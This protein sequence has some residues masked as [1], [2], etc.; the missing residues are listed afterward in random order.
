MQASASAACL[1][2]DVL[3]G[4]LSVVGPLRFN[5]VGI[6]SELGRLDVDWP[7][8]V[9]P[10]YQRGDPVLRDPTTHRVSVTDRQTVVLRG[11]WDSD[12]GVFI[13]CNVD[14]V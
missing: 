5:S 10:A 7:D 3:T 8:S 13:A 4:R 1:E 6:S 11:S 9:L 2:S 14:T 12:Q